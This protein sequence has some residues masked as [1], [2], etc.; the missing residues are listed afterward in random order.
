MNAFSTQTVMST[1][2]LEAFR[3]ERSSYSCVNTAYLTNGCGTAW[4]AKKICTR[5]SSL[6]KP[7]YILKTTKECFSTALCSR[8]GTG[9]YIWFLNRMVPLQNDQWMCKVISMEN[10][11]ER[12]SSN[13]GPV[14]WPPSSPILTSLHFFKWHYVNDIVF[15]AEISSQ[16]HM[17]ERIK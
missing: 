12:C 17:Q 10:V 13:R 8:H 4:Y 3:V 14:A 11:S 15:S 7:R 2:I 6:S 5:L 16:S 1:N 9:L